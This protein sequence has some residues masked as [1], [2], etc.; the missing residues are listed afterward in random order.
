M[1]QIKKKWDKLRD[2]KGY[3]FQSGFKNPKLEDFVY[4]FF[5]PYI[6]VQLRGQVTIIAYCFCLIISIYSHFLLRMLY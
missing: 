2:L 5:E 4:S 3:F 1:N 6:G